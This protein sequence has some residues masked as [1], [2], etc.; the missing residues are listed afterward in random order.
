MEISPRPQTRLTETLGARA[1]PHKH[2]SLVKMRTRVY[3][4]KRPTLQ[5]YLAYF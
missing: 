3:V 5:G 4:W 2:K 1:L